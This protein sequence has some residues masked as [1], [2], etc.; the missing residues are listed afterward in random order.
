MNFLKNPIS[1]ISNAAEINNLKDKRK[2][3]EKEKKANE[4]LFNRYEDQ[5][6][7]KKSSETIIGT[8]NTSLSNLRTLF[9]KSNVKYDVEFVEFSSNTKDEDMIMYKILYDKLIDT[10]KCI[11]DAIKHFDKN[12][13]VDKEVYTQK[14]AKL[15]EKIVEVNKKLDK[16]RDKQFK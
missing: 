3:L 15:D 14:I 8:N 6:K 1:S 4:K 5:I 10:N 13:S 2:E 16:V 7:L 9:T 12:I 11:E